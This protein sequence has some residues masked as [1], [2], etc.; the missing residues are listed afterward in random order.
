VLIRE[1]QNSEF[2]RRALFWTRWPSDATLIPRDFQGANTAD[3]ERETIAELGTDETTQLI[4]QLPSRL[5]ASI[6]SLMTAALLGAFGIWTGRTDLWIEL[7]RH[8]RDAFQSD[9]NTSRTLG[10]FTT[11]F[12][13]Y[14]ACNRVSPALR[15]LRLVANLLKEIPANGIPYG[16]VRY[17]TPQTDLAQ[18]LRELPR[19][20]VVFNYVGQIDRGS[21][22][23]SIFTLSH[24]ARGRGRS[25]RAL[26]TYLIEINASVVGGC[27]RVV[28]TFSEN[29]HREE[30]ISSLSAAFVKELRSLIAECAP[31]PH[32]PASWDSE[33]NWDEAELAGIHEAIRSTLKVVGQDDSN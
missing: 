12:P 7:E 32:L 28:W 4:S 5:D 8:G 1:A 3:S 22:P 27:L 6:D 26:R 30:T 18:K 13:M 29:V 25:P 23:N 15:R 20:E 16:L 17:L 33:F 24:E 11:S 31:K 19:P 9:L 14:F 10:W 21:I 2:Q